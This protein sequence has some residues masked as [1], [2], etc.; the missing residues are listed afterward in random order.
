ML[1]SYPLERDPSSP[2]EEKSSLPRFPLDP[3][4]SSPLFSDY[5]I[6][7]EDC[8]LARIVGKFSRNPLEKS[9]ERLFDADHF[10]RELSENK[11][12]EDEEKECEYEFPVEY[13]RQ[14]GKN[15]RRTEKI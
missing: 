13:V 3:S 15:C 11:E 12:E 9:K 7:G 10:L 2:L 6:H 1:S 4:L 14:R 8:T 5:P